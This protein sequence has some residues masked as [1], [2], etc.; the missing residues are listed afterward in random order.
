MKLDYNLKPTPEEEAIII[1][2]FE[3]LLISFLERKWYI[4]R[5]H[6]LLTK[7]TQNVIRRIADKIRYPGQGIKGLMALTP[8]S[9]KGDG[10]TPRTIVPTAETKSTT[11]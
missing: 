4:S 3:T 7:A 10:Y 1:R 11:R 9:M 6:P 8:I 5:L 2:D